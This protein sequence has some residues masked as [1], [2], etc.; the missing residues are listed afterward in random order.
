MLTLLQPFNLDTTKDYT[1]ANAT[2]GNLATANYYTGN[3]SLLSGVVA[4][5]ATT[6]ATVTTGAQPNITSVGTLS[7]LSVSGLIT[8]TGTGIK[9]AN[10]QDS[11]GTIT[12]TTRYGNIAGDVGVY[13]NLTAGTSGTGN[14]IASYFIGD[15]SQ[16]TSISNANTA[17]S[18]NTAATVT[19]NAQPNITS[20]GTLSS[21]T[22]SGNITGGNLVTTGKVYASDIINGGTGIYLASGPSGYINFFT[23]T[24][25]KVSIK[26]DGNIDVVGTANVGNLITS[27]NITSGNANLGNL[28]TANFFSGSGNNLSNLTFGNIT[29][30]NTAGLTID[31]LYL[32]STTRLNVTA[33]GSSGYIFDQYGVTIN[34]VL[35]VTSGQTLAFNLDVTGHPFLIQTDASANYSTGLVHVDTTGTVSTTTSAQGKIAGT[36][37]WKI[38]YGITG[39]Y[40]YQCS[41]H[42]G[43]NGNIVVTDANV[44]NIQVANATVA[45]TVYTNAQPNITSVGTLSSLIVTGNITGGNANLG[46]LVIANYFIGDGSLLTGLTGGSYSNT[47]VAAYL[48]TYTGNV[49]ANYFIGDG[50][51]LT[52]VTTSTAA[53]VTT[54][55]QPNITSIGNLTGLVVSN[56]TGI[57]DFTTSANVTL[58]NI[59][60]LHI[61]GGSSNY[62]IITDGSGNLSWAAQSGGGASV[63]GSNT[64]V[65]FNDSS[66]FGASANFTFNKT[67]NTLTVDKAIHLNGANLGSN[68]SNLYIGGGGVSQILATDGSGNLTWIAQ[69][70]AV[71]TVDNFT[72][73]GVQTVFSLSTTPANINQTMVNID[74]VFQLRSGYSLTGPNITFSEAPAN[75][76]SI[77]VTTT[78]GATSGAGAFITRAYTGTGS[79]A[80]FT[81]TSGSTVSSVIVTENGIVQAPTTD[82]TI[83]NTTLTFT[84]APASNVAIQVRELAIAIATTNAPIYRAY[85]GNGVSNTF[86][87]TSGLSANSLIVAENGII[88][89]PT[90][91]YSV[92]GSNVVFVSPPASNVDIQIRELSLN[93]GGTSSG[94]SLPTQSGNGGKYLTTDGATASWAN[95]NSSALT[96]NI[97]NSNA[98]M[99]ASNGYFVDTSG[100]AKTMTLPSSA[101]LGDTIRI[102]DLAGSFSTNNLTVARNGHKIQGNTSDLL[103]D[104]NQSSFGLVYSN[105]TYGWKVL[106]L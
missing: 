60:N 106:E 66:S 57:V 58:G 17:T 48:P 105:S 16:L 70:T 38:P 103:I 87:I 71:I 14:V 4:S 33:S 35:Y 61:T 44:A 89:R 85:T 20:V 75:G 98:T 8:A 15:G 72:G 56:S 10:I 6:A 26:D 82:Y 32:Q 7:S 45:S 88:Q 24:G 29:A 102:N 41:I 77:E 51:Q 93:G 86:T 63:A 76:Y 46:N 47:N 62:V 96:W 18:A 65:Q 9:T 104:V 19:T 25:D 79:Q 64:Q 95:V 21:L 49:S 84:T 11:T 99:T 40:K 27:G 1:F 69:P 91:D 43:M 78:M 22:V 83:S 42:G 53:T 23:S 54:N 92:S 59:S 74:G 97:A 13:G 73:N 37:Y 67:S 81:V 31:E 5:S 90:T 28:A 68:V 2:L 30:F 80:N 3:G 50:S 12:I 100:G 55:A 52:G 94:I 101:T 36:L 34:P 39:N